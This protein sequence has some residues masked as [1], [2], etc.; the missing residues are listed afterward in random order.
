M[1]VLILAISSLLFY[2]VLLGYLMVMARPGLKL[3]LKMLFW[4]IF[5]IGIGAHALVTARILI[6][7]DPDV[8]RVLAIIPLV[9]GSAVIATFHRALLRKAKMNS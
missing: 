6:E 9:I 3:L 1:T 4:F 7:N 5:S 2:L 8:Y